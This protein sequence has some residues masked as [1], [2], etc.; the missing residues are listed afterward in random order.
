MAK[1]AKVEELINQ[2]VALVR[3]SL[4]DERGLLPGV[5]YHYDEFGLIDWRQHIKDKHIVLNRNAFARES[6]D[7]DSL[8]PEKLAEYKASATEDKLLIKLPG[9]RDVA[10]LRGIV[11]A[12]PKVWWENNAV[13][14]EYIIDWLPNYETNYQKFQHGAVA[15]ASVDSVS[16]MFRPFLEAVACNRAFA[17]AVRESLCIHIV[18][19]DELD[20]NLREEV[21][22]EGSPRAVLE[23]QCIERG[24]S[25]STLALYLEG[26]GITPDEGKEWKQFSDIPDYHCLT[27]L[28]LIK[29]ESKH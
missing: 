4:R 8:S 6:I 21:I 12:T 17:R 9:F 3:P 29:D 22:P 10:R 28:K 23:K 25:F 13:I 15:S 2:E 1:K 5:E 20:P 7:V 24:V 18:G 14:C 11:S 16:P 19:Y 26:A 27:G